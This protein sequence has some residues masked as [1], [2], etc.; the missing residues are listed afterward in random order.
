MKTVK[1][2]AAKAE[3]LWHLANFLLDGSGG[4]GNAAGVTEA[5]GCIR[6]M[7]EYGFSPVQLDYLKARVLY[8]KEDWKAARKAFDAVRPKLA[9]FPPE[10]KL[11]YDCT[12]QC[13]RQEGTAD[14]ADYAFHL[15]LK[16]D[17]FD[18]KA[19]DGIAQIYIDKGRLKDA[20]G[21]YHAAAYAAPAKSTPGG[22]RAGGAALDSQPQGRRAELA[23]VRPGV[24]PRQAACSQRLANRQSDDG[25]GP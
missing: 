2:S 11:L 5:E 20:V 18:F 8:A 21:E 3:L 4:P 9:E 13:Y 10:M 7:S 17:P 19:R 15:A 12:G 25:G 24:E 22:L 16:Y 6:Q 23:G 14:Q 1:S